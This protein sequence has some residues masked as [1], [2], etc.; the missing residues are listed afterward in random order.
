MKTLAS[1]AKQLAQSVSN[2]AK[3]RDPMYVY[4]AYRLAARSAT[5]AER[6]F[7]GS[8]VLRR[9]RPA[10]LCA[11]DFDQDR[12]LHQVAEAVA[13][14]AKSSR[15]VRRAVDRALRRAVRQLKRGVPQ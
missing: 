6:H 4:L 9:W 12:G 8:L 11:E 14:V 10:S 7:R 1:C 5:D 2:K 15:C 3:A 13:A